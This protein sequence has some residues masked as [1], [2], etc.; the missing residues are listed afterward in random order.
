[1]AECVKDTA[2]ASGFLLRLL[3][4]LIFRWLH[5]AVIPRERSLSE[6]LQPAAC[7]YADDIALAAAIG[8]SLELTHARL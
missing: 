2:T 5:D 4:D 7:S 6:C 3:F 8:S 1:M